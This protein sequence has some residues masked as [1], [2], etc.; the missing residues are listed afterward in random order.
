[1]KIAEP[2][3]PSRV[4]PAAARA[5]SGV[6][7]SPASR[8]PQG[9]GDTAAVLGIPEAEL[10]PRVQGA[11]TS[12]L[13]EL[14]G[15]R[16]QLDRMMQRVADLE[17]LADRD[18]LTPLVNRRAF[19]RE[20]E[21]TAAH[22]GRHG[23]TAALALVD[24]DGLKAINDT[25]GHAAGDAA[26][27][28]VGEVLTEQ[29]RRTDLVGR[30]GGD[31]F[32]ILFVQSDVEHAR[33]KLQDMQAALARRPLRYDQ[34]VLPLDFSFG[35]QPV[36]PEMSADALIEAADKAMYRDKQARRQKT[37]AATG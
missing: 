21:R 31:E 20:L 36:V 18:T 32:V 16:G 29:T 5:P 37:L 28:R 12:L 30:L 23:S 6:A 4:T 10:T 3:G 33:G 27:L 14:Q 9:R 15:L 35:V 11:I 24:L 13:G 19:L 2:I 26:I 25:H 17:R 8:R 34:A 22:V 7:A 1:M